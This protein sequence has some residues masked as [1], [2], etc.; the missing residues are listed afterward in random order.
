METPR[1]TKVKLKGK[2][3][4]VVQAADGSPLKVTYVSGFSGEREVEL[5][6]RTA[7]ELLE[8]VRRRAERRTA[9]ARAPYA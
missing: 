2:S 9:L 4:T 3:F 5:S 7:A 8:L 6:S 1:R